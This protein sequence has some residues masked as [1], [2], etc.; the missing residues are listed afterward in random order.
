MCRV[1]YSDGSRTVH[2]F[3]CA[4][5]Q[6]GRGV[7]EWVGAGCVGFS[8]AVRKKKKKGSFMTSVSFCS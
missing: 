6:E 8:G 4:C 2:V 5:T 3:L 1:T 7:G